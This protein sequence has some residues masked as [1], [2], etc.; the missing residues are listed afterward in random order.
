MLRDDPLFK[1]FTDPEDIGHVG[2]LPVV[3]DEIEQG[4]LYQLR[5]LWLV[6][7]EGHKLRNPARPLFR[8]GLHLAARSHTSVVMTA[9]PLVSSP[10]VR[11]PA[12]CSI[13]FMLLF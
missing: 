5:A 3:G 10:A 7:D 4:T 9:T 6:L 8:S 13:A 2:P 12:R 1:T 11:T